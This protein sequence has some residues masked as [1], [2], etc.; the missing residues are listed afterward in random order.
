M[1]NCALDER[2]GID[3]AA[4][5]GTHLSDAH[6]L[7]WKR[8]Q[9]R[10]GRTG[11]PESRSHFEKDDQVTTDTKTMSATPFAAGSADSSMDSIL[12]DSIDN[13][14]MDKN[15]HDEFSVLSHDGQEFSG[16][17]SEPICCKQASE[18]STS[19]SVI[20]TD[21]VLAH[22]ANI[23]KREVEQATWSYASCVLKQPWETGCM[24]AIFANDNSP[25][26]HLWPALEAVPLPEVRTDV[27]H[28]QPSKRTKTGPKPDVHVHAFHGIMD[29]G[30]NADA[31]PDQVK[32][33]AVEK[34]FALLR[35]HGACFELAAGTPAN[36]MGDV[37]LKESIRAALGV[38]SPLT[39]R[40]RI[41]AVL[42]YVKWMERHA[43]TNIFPLSELHV[44]EHF[45]ALKHENAAATRASSFLEAVNFMTH[46]LGLSTDSN[47]RSS[48]RIAGI[49]QALLSAKGVW[50]QAE[51]LSVDQVRTLHV[52]LEDGER[53]D[54]DR[55]AAAVFL[56]CIYSRSRWSDIRSLESISLDLSG[57]S[58]FIEATTRTHKGTRTAAKKSK[59]LPLTGIARGVT[60]GCW[61]RLLLE[62][63]SRVGLCMQEPIGPLLPCPISDGGTW[64]QFAVSA[65]GASTWLRALLH[66]D[67]KSNVSSHSLKTTGLS[68]CAKAGVCREHRLLL[69]RHSSSIAT[70]DSYYSRDLLAQPLQ[71]LQDTV[72]SIREA[73]FLPDCTRSGR[74]V[75]KGNGEVASSKAELPPSE[76]PGAQDDEGSLS[77]KESTSS[78]SSDSKEIPS[79]LTLQQIGPALEE[80]GLVKHKKSGIVHKL[81]SLADGRLICGRKVAEAHLPVPTESAAKAVWC[82]KCI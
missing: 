17:V 60:G 13:E 12:V 43:K 78:S 39:I 44:W 68:W 72:D 71:D 69:G 40:K 22:F 5:E 31:S 42:Q 18:S 63:R 4:V 3:A 35:Q 54:I 25:S 45:T 79:E 81:D 74:F 23:H 51:A 66:V 52:V 62:L 46:V 77:E 53:H 8:R 7:P 16:A 67:V 64:T 21:D 75:G 65:S 55:Y 29:R 57:D 76:E 38:K 70:S 15:L 47:V 30:I 6:G 9:H 11:S 2:G 56:F 48:K 32:H 1:D 41:G 33:D 59:L 73:T 10:M 20:E 49:S 19:F 80:S 50:R 82:M 36:K 37:E 14:C 24:S 27:E 61:P 58:G 26:F 34:W 28:A